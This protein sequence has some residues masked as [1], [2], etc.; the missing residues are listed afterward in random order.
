MSFTHSFEHRV[1][2]TRLLYRQ[3]LHR[4]PADAEIIP[5]ASSSLDLL[6]IEA[7]IL[8]S[9]EFMNAG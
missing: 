9:N 7:L 4:T 2:F 6:G 3:F 5:I 8:A 1:R